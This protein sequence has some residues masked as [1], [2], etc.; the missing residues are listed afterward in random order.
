M[1]KLQAEN[2]SKDTYRELLIAIGICMCRVIPWIGTFLHQNEACQKIHLPTYPFLKK[3]CWHGS[4]I[5][6]EKSIDSQEPA[7]HDDAAI[8]KLVS[9]QQTNQQSNSKISLLLTVMAQHLQVIKK[10][11]YLISIY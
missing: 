11:N 4:N 8:K 9:S 5:L 7:Q 1:R 10:L 2:I 6:K 3:K